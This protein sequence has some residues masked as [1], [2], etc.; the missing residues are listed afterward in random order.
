VATGLFYHDV[1]AALSEGGVPFVVVGGVAV[2]LQGVPRFTADLDVAV[3]LDGAI[4]ARVAEVLE[5]IGLRCR[6][7][8]SRA[9][10]AD[11][12]TVRGWIAERNLRAITFADPTQALREVDVVVASP[13]PYADL[14]RTAEQMS[15][16]GLA[17]RVASI[18][19]LIAMKTGT[20]RAQDDSDVEALRKVLEAS[21]G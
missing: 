20:G 8:V 17:F 18:E 15:A 3:A 11:A 12:E 10:L 7:P 13:V 9:E 4:L 14:Q 2:N 5:G 1:L 21:R 6:L 19:K 16:G